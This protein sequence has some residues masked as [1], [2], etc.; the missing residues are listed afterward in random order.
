M[1]ESIGIE[2][3]NFSLIRGQKE[4]YRNFSINFEKNKTTAILA[5]SGTGKTS[6]LDAISGLLPYQSGTIECAKTKNKVSISYLFQEPR[7]LPWATVLQN[8]LLPI[9]TLFSKA[10]AIKR[11]EYYLSLYNILERKNA[12]PNELSGGEKQRC[13]LARTFAFPSSIL[14]MDEAFQSQDIA[15]KKQLFSLFKSIL[16]KEPRTVILVTHDIDEALFL[17]DRIIVLQHEKK[18]SV[19]K[20]I[21]DK[22]VDEINTKEILQEITGLL[23]SI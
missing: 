7:L 3:R 1:N 5:P 22:K 15:L 4:L 8:C 16:Q 23:S 9:E 2:I 18:E 11:T 13:A 17:A 21:M 20:K 12:F 10:E 14:L 19:L 6:L